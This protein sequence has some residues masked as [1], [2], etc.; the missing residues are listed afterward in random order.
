M[1]K[2][3]FFKIVYCILKELYACKKQ[4]CRVNLHDISPERFGINEG[5]LLDILVELLE[6]GYVKGFSIRKTKGTGIC[7]LGLT[8]ITITMKGIEYL[9][10]NAKMKKVYET[11][12]EV[13]DW[14]P[15]L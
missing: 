6:E 13:K 7:V 9:Q 15:G 12:K 3:D 5:Y 10:D 4:G 11:L 8:D 1:A 2:D 14:F